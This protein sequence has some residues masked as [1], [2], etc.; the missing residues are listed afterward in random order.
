M[1]LSANRDISSFATYRDVVVNI[2]V[3]GGVHIYKGA[4][5]NV[6]ATGYAKPASDTTGEKFIGLAMEEVDNS[7]GGDGAKTIKIARNK[8]I[9]YPA[10]SPDLADIGK[11]VYIVDDEDLTDDD[12]ALTASIKAGVIVKVETSG[13]FAG[14]TVALNEGAL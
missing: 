7:G 14:W 2:P 11:E 9:I 8:Y 6:N 5:V 10:A 1:A 13:E 4:F 12:T 3:A